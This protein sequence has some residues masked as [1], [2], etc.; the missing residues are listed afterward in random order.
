MSCTRASSVQISEI[1]NEWREEYDFK[2]SLIG[3]MNFDSFFCFQYSAEPCY[4]AWLFSLSLSS[5]FV[6]THTHIS[7]HF[8]IF[9]AACCDFY[10]EW[11]S[12]ERM[13]YVLCHQQIIFELT[14]HFIRSNAPT[15]SCAV[16]QLVSVSWLF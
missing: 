7:M 5:P 10:T 4:F 11:K 1:E 6:R 8:S 13:P 3:K 9:F 14:T 2:Y 15:C 12:K 16:Y